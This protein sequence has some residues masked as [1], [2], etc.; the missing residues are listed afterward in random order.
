MGHDVVDVTVRLAAVVQREDRR[1]LELGGDL[2][3]AK[4]ALGAE[5]RGEVRVQDLHRD[6]AVVLQVLGEVDRSH[7]AG[8]QLAHEA[9]AV[10][11]WPH[12]P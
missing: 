12:E 8:P 5:Q 11:E 6:F 2:D 9:V 10:A 1:V 4:K 3:L 7:A